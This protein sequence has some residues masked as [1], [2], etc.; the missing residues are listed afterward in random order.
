MGLFDAIA[1]HFPPEWGLMLS[2][3]VK[4]IENVDDWSLFLMLA[5]LTLYELNLHSSFFHFIKIAAVNKVTTLPKAKEQSTKFCEILQ[6]L[7]F[8]YDLI[9]FLHFYKA[10]KLLL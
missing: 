8:T 6:Y 4:V 3:R 5:I 7:N 1:I 10:F 9:A 2:F